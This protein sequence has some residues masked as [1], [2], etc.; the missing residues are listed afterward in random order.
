MIRL[1]MI[2]LL[3]VVGKKI[4]RE[5]VTMVEHKCT[6]VDLAHMCNVVAQF[7]GIPMGVSPS[8]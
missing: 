2:L 6:C 4:Y 8:G 1:H 3:V 5:D 7:Y